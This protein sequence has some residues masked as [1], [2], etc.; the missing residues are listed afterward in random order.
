MAIQSLRALN[1]T[2]CRNAPRQAVQHD[3]QLECS[4]VKDMNI[5]S[6]ECS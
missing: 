2:L 6:K 4:Y 5:K 1:V 3:F